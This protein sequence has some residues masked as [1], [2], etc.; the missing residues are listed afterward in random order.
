Y[1]I[2]SPQYVTVVSQS[3][4]PLPATPAPT[5]APTP[6]TSSAPQSATAPRLDGISLSPSSPQA[7]QA[8]TATITGSGFQSGVVLLYSG[9]SYPA[10]FNNS[11]SLTFS[12]GGL[13]AGSYNFWVRNPDGQTSNSLTVTIASPAVTYIWNIS[14]SG[15]RLA[16]GQST[17]SVTVYWTGSPTAAVYYNG[18][19]VCGPASSGSCSFN[20]PQGSYIGELRDTSTGA[21]MRTITLPVDPPA[22]DTSNKVGLIADP[23]VANALEALGSTLLN[24][25]D[26]LRS[27]R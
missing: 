2:Q 17:C 23:R 8:F 3:P 20:L 25:V 12:S 15:C 11:G 22:P 24:F 13:A 4:P 26:L 9:V 14:G 19:A 1:G 5:T 18:S 7:N 16:A 21:V 27:R 10:T 6:T